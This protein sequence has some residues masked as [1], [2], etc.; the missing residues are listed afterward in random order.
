MHPRQACRGSGIAAT[1]I[2][3]FPVDE[4]DPSNP[5]IAPKTKYLYLGTVYICNC[6]WRG[7]GGG[8]IIPTR[9]RKR[10]EKERKGN[11]KMNTKKKK[12]KRTILLIATVH[13]SVR[14]WVYP[15]YT[16]LQCHLHPCY[17]T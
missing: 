4:D 1:G 17:A 11:S 9:L 8:W 15:P 5:G 7:A 6:M 2:E 14:S 16:E 10:R 13:L 12:K 3:A